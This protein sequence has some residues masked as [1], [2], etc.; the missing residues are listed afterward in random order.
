MLEGGVKGRGSDECQ[1]NFK[2][3]MRLGMKL[4]FSILEDI[5]VTQGGIFHSGVEKVLGLWEEIEVE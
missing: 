4:S 1:C 5:S 3:G 2:I